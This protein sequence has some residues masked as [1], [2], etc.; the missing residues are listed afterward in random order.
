MPILSTLRFLVRSR[1][2]AT[3][4]TATPVFLRIK[5]KTAGPYRKSSWLSCGWSRRRGS[6]PGAT[7][8][9]SPSA[10]DFPRMNWLIHALIRKTLTD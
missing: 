2:Q 6:P 9:P 4:I 3:R 7:G 1:G 10:R 8:L 5:E